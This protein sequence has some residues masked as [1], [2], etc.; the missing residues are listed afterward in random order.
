M[1]IKFTK[2]YLEELYAFGKSN[3]KKYRF[4]KD[5]IKRYKNTIDKLRVANKI[6]DLYPIKSLNY[7]KLS[8]DKQG[9]ESVRVNDKY[10]IEFSSSIEGEEPYTITICEIVELSNHYS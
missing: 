4:Q 9:L 5:I 2:A 1:E 10:R 8:G 7:E 6:E 3:S